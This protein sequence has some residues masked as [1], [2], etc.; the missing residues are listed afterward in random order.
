MKGSDGLW[1]FACGDVFTWLGRCP[2]GSS[3]VHLKVFKK[4]CQTLCHQGVFSWQ[5]IS[6]KNTILELVANYCDFCNVSDTKIPLS[7]PK[8]NSE[9]KLN[10]YKLNTSFNQGNI[11][12]VWKL[13][14]WPSYKFL[15][16]WTCHICVET[17]SLWRICQQKNINW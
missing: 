1:R 11:I 5:Q 16:I 7:V 4:P 3:C 13:A 12:Y 6:K 8:Q 17:P 9:T 2:H 14:L 15:I 10:A